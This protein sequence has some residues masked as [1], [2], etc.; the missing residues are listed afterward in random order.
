ME[1]HCDGYAAAVPIGTRPDG[2][3]RMADE[4][5]MSKSRVSKSK[6]RMIADME[7]D[8]RRRRWGPILQ[9]QSGREDD[10]DMDLPDWWLEAVQIY[11]DD[12]AFDEEYASVV[13]QMRFRDPDNKFFVV[14]DYSCESPFKTDKKQDDWGT[15]YAERLT[16]AIEAQIPNYPSDTK[17]TVTL[18]TFFEA[19]KKTSLYE[20]AREDKRVGEGLMIMFYDE[21][22]R[23][24]G[25][26]AKYIFTLKNH[27]RESSIYAGT[28]HES[29]HY[30]RRI[31]M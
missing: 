3:K 23:S 7:W 31:R 24:Y 4:P 2:R 26:V 5:G 27:P 28:G 8:T 11:R 14:L 1:V 9:R 19:L 6:D 10:L 15:A 20:D 22:P 17:K 12:S 16:E 30:T 13:S 21:E 29:E 25:E 18:Y